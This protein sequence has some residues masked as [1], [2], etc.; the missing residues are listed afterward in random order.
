MKRQ[1]LLLI[2][3]VSIL[4]VF[5]IAPLIYIIYESFFNRNLS[6]PWHVEFIGIANYVRALKSSTFWH[7]LKVTLDYLI[8]ALPIQLF[9]GLSIALML[10]KLKYGAGGYKLILSLPLV[11]SP[12]AA[13]VMW[14]LIFDPRTSPINYM[15]SI[16]GLR[17][18][19]WL[20]DS[21]VAL[22]S[23]VIV[24]T[25]QWT[26]FVWL[27]LLA[28]LNAIPLEVFE[29]AQL[30]GARPLL[31]LRYIT[32]PLLK[33]Q[34]ILVIL[35]RALM[36]LKDFDKIFILTAGGPAEATE[37]LSLHTYYSIFWWFDIGYGS[38]LAILYLIL[39]IIATTIL[40][41]KVKL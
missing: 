37:T 13:A 16:I 35:F 26:P 30:D 41:R 29:A 9:L 27:V 36:L 32:L 38:T 20:G 28:G 12:A 8:R 21:T 40:F 19:T 2:P 14:R 11:L 5:G 23:V 10:Y 39:V 4:F 6:I 15:A 1:F 18:P 31:I 7:T 17:A 22:W 33:P 3:T 34:I 25:W 24:D